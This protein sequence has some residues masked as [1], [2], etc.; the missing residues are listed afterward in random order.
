[1][2]RRHAWNLGIIE[3]RRLEVFRGI[4]VRI[5]VLSVAH[6]KVFCG[7]SYRGSHRGVLEDTLY[8]ECV[9]KLQLRWLQVL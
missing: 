6:A 7:S 5:V 8:Q 3:A 1:M 9:I 2:V 4:R